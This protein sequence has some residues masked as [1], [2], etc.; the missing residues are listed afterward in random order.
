M[1]LVAAVPVVVCNMALPVLLAAPVVVCDL[2]LVGH[3]C[4]PVPTAG[5]VDVL[6]PGI[7]VLSAAAS[8]VS[9]PVVY[10]R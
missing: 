9:A 10:L 6:A 7:G 3:A 1:V 8:L 2:A 5:A 4:V